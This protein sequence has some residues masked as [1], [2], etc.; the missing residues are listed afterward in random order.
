[1]KV[2]AQDRALKDN[3]EGLRTTIILTMTY[4]GVPNTNLE[5]KPF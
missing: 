1:M 2:A 4:D 5:Q 3:E